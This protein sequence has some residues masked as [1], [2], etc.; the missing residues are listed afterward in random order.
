MYQ[1]RQYCLLQHCRTSTGILPRERKLQDSLPVRRIL[2]RCGLKECIM[3][4][5]VGQDNC[6]SSEFLIDRVHN[7]QSKNG[8]YCDE[9]LDYRLALLNKPK[10]RTVDSLDSDGVIRLIC[11]TTPGVKCCFITYIFQAIRYICPCG[12]DFNPD[13]KPACGICGRRCRIPS[14]ND[15]FC[16]EQEAK[17]PD[18]LF[19]KIIKNVLNNA[20]KSKDRKGVQI[21][22]YEKYEL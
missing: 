4:D 3:K 20:E 10:T 22:T 1:D 11:W 9:C 2:A 14:L 8:H 12:K 13:I 7:H 15:S 19:L 6:T 17:N 5:L 18:L 16:R 21:F